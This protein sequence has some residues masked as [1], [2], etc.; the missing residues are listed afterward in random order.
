MAVHNN[1][2]ITEK[3]KENFDS[4]IAP[5]SFHVGQLVWLNEHNF[6]GRNRKLSPNFT[7]PHTIVQIFGDSVVELRVNNK[8]MRVNSCR[9]K[10]YL[11]P[12]QIQFRNTDL[13]HDQSSNNLPIPNLDPR[14]N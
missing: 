7:G 9:L 6:L 2:E 8:R 10:P 3:S 4:K 11:P 13:P 5:T 12:R 1:V 14:L